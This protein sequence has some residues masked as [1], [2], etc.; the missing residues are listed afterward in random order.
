MLDQNPD[1]TG[2]WKLVMLVHANN[3]ALRFALT[4]KNLRHSMIKEFLL[5]PQYL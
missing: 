1:R 2:M 5:Q 3:R 4:S